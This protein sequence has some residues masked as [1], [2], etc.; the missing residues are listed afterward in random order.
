[1]VSDPDITAGLGG[2]KTSEPGA[3]IIAPLQFLFN[4]M[5]DNVPAKPYHEDGNIEWYKRE[6]RRARRKLK[7]NV[8]VK[9]AIMDFIDKNF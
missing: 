5:R 2:A 9:A 8:E 6:N 3:Q 4:P 1:M 7:Q